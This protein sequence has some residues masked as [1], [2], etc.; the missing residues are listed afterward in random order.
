DETAVCTRQ[1]CAYR[2]SYSDF[3]AA[4]AE[5]L[6]ISPQ[7]VDSHEKFSNHHSF[8]FPLLADPE[9]S[10]ISAWGLKGPFGMT[11]RAVFLIDEGGTV[12]WKHVS[13]TGLTYRSS[14]EL[15]KHLQ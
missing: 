6:G 1:L 8:P 13:P 4:G 12:V 5:V 7:S 10:V 3:M 11:R 2:D 14:A 9:R 15:L